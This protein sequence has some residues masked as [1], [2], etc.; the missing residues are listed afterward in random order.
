MLHIHRMKE[1]LLQAQVLDEG[2]ETGKVA[3]GAF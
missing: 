1:S 2:V 3:A